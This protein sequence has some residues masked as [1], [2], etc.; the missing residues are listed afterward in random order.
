MDVQATL[1]GEQCSTLLT[2]KLLLACMGESVRRETTLAGEAVATLVTLKPLLATVDEAMGLERTLT[3]EQLG[4]YLTSK[5]LLTYTGNSGGEASEVLVLQDGHAGDGRDSLFSVH[6][7][8][9]AEVCLLGQEST[10]LL[11][12]KLLFPAMHNHV[13][14]VVLVGKLFATLLTTEHGLYVWDEHRVSDKCIW[15]G[16]KTRCRRLR[17]LACHNHAHA[18]AQHLLP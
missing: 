7:H 10:A 16:I 17:G 9:G 14:D 18:N 3:R 5:P 11:A 2:L 4:T 8:V 12:G 1:P 6:Q 15:M 13:S